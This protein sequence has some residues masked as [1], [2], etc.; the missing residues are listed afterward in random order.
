MHNYRFEHIKFK[1]KND[2]YYIVDFGTPRFSEID[3]YHVMWNGHYINYFEAARI[4]LCRHIGFD[5]DSLVK[6]GCYLP[7]YNYDIT[8][9]KPV[10]AGEKISVAV[11]PQE[12]SHS[13]I[14]FKHILLVDGEVRAYGEVQHIPTDTESLNII[15]NLSEEIV[16]I[17]APF[18]KVFGLENSTISH[19]HK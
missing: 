2:K 12:L 7:V 8:M 6:L 15:Y 9:K 16:E 1:R 13:S 11:T 19:N 18:I 17:L 5:L 14:K 4:E 3:S 10:L